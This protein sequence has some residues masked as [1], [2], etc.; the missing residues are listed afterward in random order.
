MPGELLSTFLLQSLQRS[1]PQIQTSQPESIEELVF[2]NP[3]KTAE[4]VFDD[5]LPAVES[6]E[7]Y[8]ISYVGSQG[9]GKSHSAAG[10]ATLALK[11]GFLVIYAKAADIFPDLQGWIAKVKELLKEHGNPKVCFVYDD[12]SY[13]TGTVSSKAAA[14]FKNFIADMRHEFEQVF[15]TIQIL[16]LYISHRYHSVPPMLRNSATWIFAS[17]QP[18]DRLDAMKLIPNHKEQKDKLEAIYM[19]LSKVTQDGPKYVNLKFSIGGNE[20]NFRWGKKGDPGDGRLMMSFHRG[21]L[22]IFNAKQLE[23]QIDLEDHRIKYVAPT[24]PTPEQIESLNERKKEAL[25][26]KAE[27]LFNKSQQPEIE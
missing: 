9:H 7:F 6:N 17:M 5:I 10:F 15:G 13:S 11:K 23:G 22:R 12:M 2:R 26:A 4:E 14:K 20:F 3:F 16:I 19:F 1:Q 8:A 25:R 18:E 27:E 24:P 21:E